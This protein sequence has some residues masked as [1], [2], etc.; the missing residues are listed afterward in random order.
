MRCNF[1]GIPPSGKKIK[2]RG[3]QISRFVDGKIVER[4][5]SSDELGI[6]QQIGALKPAASISE[7][8]ALSGKSA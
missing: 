2:A 6:M 1:A 7:E 5:G 4:W 3:M 8:P